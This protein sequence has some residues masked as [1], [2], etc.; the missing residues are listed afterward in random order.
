MDMDKGC[1][2]VNVVKVSNSISVVALA[3]EAVEGSPQPNPLDLDFR[4]IGDLPIDLDI[5]EEQPCRRSG[6]APDE[7]GCR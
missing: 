2:E 5:P 4:G 3:I 1:S 6:K 7:G